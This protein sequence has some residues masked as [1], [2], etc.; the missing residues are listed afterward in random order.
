[1]GYTCTCKGLCPNGTQACRHVKSTSA[2]MHVSMP[3]RAR[4]CTAAEALSGRIEVSLTTLPWLR[5]VRVSSF[6][7]NAEVE[8]AVLA[9]SCVF[10]MHPVWLPSL[11]AW[12]IDGGYSDFQILKA[13]GFSVQ[14]GR[15]LPAC[16]S[17]CR[18]HVTLSTHPCH[19]C[20]WHPSSA[21]PFKLLPADW[22]AGL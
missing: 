8:D 22:V 15:P 11:G 7:S 18:M 3:D 4:A 21:V 19:G 16:G 6:G 13:R 12:G 9:S 1:M 17:A 20:A 5:N 2:E 14:H 10:A